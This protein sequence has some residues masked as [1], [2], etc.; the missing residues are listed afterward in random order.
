VIKY[1]GLGLKR[2]EAW[3]ITGL[4]K[5]QFYHKPTGGKRGRK[6]SEATLKV[7]ESGFITVD[8]TVVIEQIKDFHK[9][10]DLC[11]GYKRMCAMLMLCG[12][13]INKKKV[14]RLMAENDLLNPPVKR[15]GRNFARYR[16]VIPEGPLEVIEMDIKHIWIDSEH[17]SAYIL[18][19]IDTF[20]RVVLSWQVGFTMKSY[21]VENMWKEVIENH[22]E[23]HGMRFKQLSI[24]V[25]NDNGPQFKSAIIQQFFKENYLNQVFTHPYTPQ[26][27][28]H[29]ESFHKI[30]SN[31]LNPSYWSLTELEMRLNRFYEAYNTL[32][33]H[34]SIANLP[35]QMFWKLWDMQ[36]IER[37]LLQN[38][39][40][41]FILKCNVQDIP[42]I[43]S[44]REHLAIKTGAK[45]TD[46]I[47]NGG[48]EITHAAIMN[49]PVYQSPSVT[50]CTTN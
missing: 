12:Y 11:S 30:L 49:T 24:E 44:Q 4:T 19:A 38:K 5:H 29:I 15:I 39:K 7:T 46:V 16:I 42:G 14:Q 21:Q 23:P 33:V 9:D 1:V 28:G 48:T 18:T 47:K 20:T 45:H 34:G 6:R 31:A 36:L 2:S 10:P 41:R 37:K 35:P 43:I 17:R 13:I 22:L 25:R 32:R 3:L 8:N 40:V 50:S 26:E 27:N